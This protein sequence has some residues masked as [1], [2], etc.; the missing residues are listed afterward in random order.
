MQAPLRGAASPP[1]S[2]PLKTVQESDLEELRFKW[3]QQVK[4]IEV[5]NSHF[6]IKFSNS[7]FL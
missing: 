5:S 4:L 3:K 2:S 6:L 1:M 7:F